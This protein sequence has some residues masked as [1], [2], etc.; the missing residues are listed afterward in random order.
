ML[1][2]F[3]PERSGPLATVVHAVL[4]DWSPVRVTTDGGNTHRVAQALASGPLMVALPAVLGWQGAYGPVQYRWLSFNA[5]GTLAF[6]A[7]PLH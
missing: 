7:V 6:Q 1:A 5:A 4:K 3:T 2:R